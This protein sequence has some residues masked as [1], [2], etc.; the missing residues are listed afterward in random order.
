MTSAH[1]LS[2]SPT[3]RR[4]RFS[5]RFESRLQRRNC[6]CPRS[7]GPQAPR[8]FSGTGCRCG[9][10]SAAVSASDCP[11]P[12]REGK[13]EGALRSCWIIGFLCVGV[14]Q[15]GSY[16]PWREP[17][18]GINQSF[19]KPCV[20]K[21][22]ENKKIEFFS[23]PYINFSPDP[24]HCFPCDSSFFLGQNPECCH[25]SALAPLRSGLGD[26]AH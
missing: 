16:F 2:W 25:V 4:G 21:C 10:I 26:L 9:S 17:V 3:V 15:V 20:V 1:T 23:F 11:R 8:C 14:M 24:S 13:Q 6:W 18:E 22:C 7:T 12:R 19:L 5:V